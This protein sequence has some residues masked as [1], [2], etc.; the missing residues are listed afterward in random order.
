M[1]DK[2]AVFEDLIMADSDMLAAAKAEVERL[3]A[4][5]GDTI[6]LDAGTTYTGNFYL[7]PKS[8]PN[9]K[10]IHIVSSALNRLPSPGTQVSTT[11]AVNMPKIVTPNVSAALTVIA[12]SSYYRLVGLEITSA[13]VQG[14]NPSHNPPLNC[15]TYML[16]DIT[17][18]GIKA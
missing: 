14:C 11:D 1:S 17:I 10:W 7:I 6:V 16:V 5:P 15:L 9:H 2:S 12:G 8:N 3:E 4:S 18:G 13:S